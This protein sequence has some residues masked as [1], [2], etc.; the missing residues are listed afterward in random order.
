[1]RIHVLLSNLCAFY[2][3]SVMNVQ[4]IKEMDFD[5]IPPLL[6]QTVVHAVECV[7]VLLV[8]ALSLDPTGTA[9]HHLISVLY[10]LLALELAL[11]GH[12]DTLN[13]CLSSSCRNQKGIASAALLNSF[14]RVHHTYMSPLGLTRRGTLLSAGLAAIEIAVDEAITRLIKG[15]KD[16]LVTFVFP[17]LYANSMSVKIAAQT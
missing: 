16:I 1:M 4:G 17:Q 2:T 5:P 9:Q 11:K 12:S 7:S 15:Y 10:S 6:V 13:R 14:S 8:S 3:F